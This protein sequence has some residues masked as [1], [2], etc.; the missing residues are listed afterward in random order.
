MHYFH[1]ELRPLG[2]QIDSYFALKFYQIQGILGRFLLQLYITLV[3]ITASQQVNI[4][5]CQPIFCRWFGWQGSIV[6]GESKALK[7]VT[8]RNLV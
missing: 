6:G 1:M 4:Q 8:E 5:C 7:T 2:L 3:I